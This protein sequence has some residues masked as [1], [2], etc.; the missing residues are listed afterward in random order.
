MEGFNI[1][2]AGQN[3]EAKVR[4]WIENNTYHINIHD[5]PL[6]FEYIRNMSAKEVT[7]KTFQELSDLIL[8]D[9]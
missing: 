2:V 3:T 8:L 9:Y 7:L 1:N 4:D 6:F 5:N